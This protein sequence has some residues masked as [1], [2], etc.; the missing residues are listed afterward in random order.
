LSICVIVYDER[1]KIMA[2]KLSFFT[3]VWENKRCKK[4][5]TQMMRKEEAN[6]EKNEL[7]SKKLLTNSN[8]TI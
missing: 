6:P 3:K 1:P 5:G 8:L 7:L 2:L 4:W